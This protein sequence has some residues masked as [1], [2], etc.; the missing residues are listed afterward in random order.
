[1]ERLRHE[2]DSVL[3][4]IELAETGGDLA[5]EYSRTGKV[6][7]ARQAIEHYQEAAL[8]YSS[9][10]KDVNPRKLFGYYQTAFDISLDVLSKLNRNSESKTVEQ[11]KIFTEYLTKSFE[12]ARKVTEGAAKSVERSIYKA[13]ARSVADEMRRILDNMRNEMTAMAPLL[14]KSGSIP[15]VDIPPK[16]STHESL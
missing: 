6:D 1:M 2:D 3:R 11:E 7:L 12:E 10:D 14:S 4:A 5:K 9:T 16:Q 13:G 8:A 15:S